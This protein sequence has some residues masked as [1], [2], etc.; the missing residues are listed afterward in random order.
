MPT[1]ALA[2]AAKFRWARETRS[3]GAGYLWRN[4][5]FLAGLAVAVVLL[6]T[7]FWI[8]HATEQA[9]RDKLREGL[10]TLAATSAVALV[11]W[12]EKELSNADN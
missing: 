3:V 7:G 1:K 6:V 12:A 5:V 11:F 9:L 8:H 10:D 4:P 2:N